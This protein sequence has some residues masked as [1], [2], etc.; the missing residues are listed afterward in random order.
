MKHRRWLGLA[1]A[2][3]LF[4]ATGCGPDIAGVCDE[5]EKCLGGNDADIEACNVAAEGAYETA[6]DIGC[7][8]EFDAVLTCLQPELACISGNACMTDNDCNGQ[9]ACS[10]G[11]CKSYTL[12]GNNQ[13]ACEK[14]QNAYSRC[15]GN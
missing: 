15:V 8:D 14:E 10:G 2:F 3:V 6:S 9:S 5:Q 11:T 13:D 4:E 12:D 7:A 1:F